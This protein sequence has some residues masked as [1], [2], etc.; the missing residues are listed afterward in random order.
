MNPHDQYNLKPVQVC[1][2]NEG[3][4]PPSPSLF[5]RFGGGGWYLP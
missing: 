1:M 2:P 5:D 3:V 4:Y